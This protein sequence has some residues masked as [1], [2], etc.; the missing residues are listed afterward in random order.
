MLAQILILVAEGNE[1]CVFHNLD[2]EGRLGKVCAHR[3]A[4]SHL[5][6]LFVVLSLRREY[7]NVPFPLPLT[8]NFFFCR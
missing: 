7:R 2:N 4:V 5:L 8:P 1:I 3:L 6:T